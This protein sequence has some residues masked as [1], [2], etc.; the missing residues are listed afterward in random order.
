MLIDKPAFADDGFAFRCRQPRCSSNRG[1]VPGQGGPWFVMLVMLMDNGLEPSCG[2]P[3]SRA[4]SG[5]EF[6][7]ALARH[8]AGFPILLEQSK[9]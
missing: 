1:R 2:S 5:I 6:L 4:H 8:L 3:Y 7:L 9:E